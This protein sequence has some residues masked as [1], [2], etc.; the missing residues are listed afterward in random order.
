MQS[1]LLTIYNKLKLSGEINGT[2]PNESRNDSNLMTDESVGLRY[3]K[4]EQKTVTN[5][6]RLSDCSSVQECLDKLQYEEK[7]PF[8]TNV[9]EF[10]KSKSFKNCII[11]KIATVAL[12]APATQVSVER[13]FSALP[14]V[15]TKYRYNLN[16]EH[17]ENILLVKLNPSLMEKISMN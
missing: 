4:L 12:A 16:S 8:C 13:A 3:Q 6:T 7:L 1:H 5:F 9:L 10:W 14:V 15:L 17:L 2:F 11:S